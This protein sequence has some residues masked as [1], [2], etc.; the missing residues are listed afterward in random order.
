MNR[1]CF[2][3]VPWPVWGVS[4]LLTF[5]TTDH[6]AMGLFLWLGG[7]G[8][9][10][11]PWFASQHA[12]SKPHSRIYQQTQHILQLFNLPF[13]RAAF[14]EPVTFQNLYSKLLGKRRREGIF[15]PLFRQ[16]T[17]DALPIDLEL[18]RGHS[19]AKSKR[20]RSCRWI[21]D[22]R[23]KNYIRTFRTT[24]KMWIGEAAA[25]DLHCLM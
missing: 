19:G 14:T 10:P 4:F 22:K 3:H 7:C 5:L 15:P 6:V 24:T 13:C 16:T 1:K 8:S 20:K 9:N 18:P 21:T 25:L 11:N 2:K 12:A 23:K 17:S